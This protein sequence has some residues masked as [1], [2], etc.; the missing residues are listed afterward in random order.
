MVVQ[1]KKISKKAAERKWKGKDWFSISAPDWLGGGKMADTPA[2]DSKVVKGRVFEMPV[3]ELTKDQ[4][5]Y[6]MRLRLKAEKPEDNEVKTKF[7]SFFAVNEYV[8]RMGRKGLGKVT[9][10]A[11]VETK[12]KWLLQVSVVAILNRRANSEIKKKVRE[13]AIKTLAAKAKDLNHDD[14][15]KATMAGVFQMKVKK[16]ASK[17]YPVRFTEVIKIETLK[18]GE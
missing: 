2:T 11:D 16:G 14:F 9:V 10:F 1:K 3:S 18:R 8:M 17:I 6:Y 5:K 12:D 13:F 15:V 4:S 7:H